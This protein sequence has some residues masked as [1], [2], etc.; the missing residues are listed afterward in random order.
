MAIATTMA[1]TPSMA[2]EACHPNAAIASAAVAPTTTVPTLPPATWAAIAVPIRRGGNCSASSALPTGCCGAPPMRET[3][4]AIANPPKP[5][6]I[7]W[8][9]IPAPVSSPPPP[10]SVGRP[11]Y[12]VSDAERVLEQAA[13][14]PADRRQ[15][16]DRRRRDAELVDD[17]E[18]DERVER[19]LAV[20]DR[21]LDA[22]QPEGQAR[23]DPGAGRGFGGFGRRG[24]GGRGFGRGLDRGLGH[25][26][27]HRPTV[28]RATAHPDHG[29][30]RRT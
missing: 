17:R 9:A 11:T 6:A 28:G 5:V 24:F 12:R 16:D 23:P 20:D 10:S 21:V 4:F 27:A 3:T 25:G 8:A 26:G 7:A 1:A 15:D 14:D 13:R 29:A 19:R 18:I 2:T 30:A 22:E